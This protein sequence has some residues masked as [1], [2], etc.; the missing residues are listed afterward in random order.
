MNQDSQLETPKAAPVSD[1]VPLLAKISYSVGGINDLYG[2]W[3]YNTLAMAVFNIHL[4][5]PPEK[6]GLALMITR[7]LDGF[8]DPV[9]GTLSDNTRTRFGRRRPFILIGSILSGLALPVMF[10]A[11]P[12][13]THAQLFLFMVVSGLLYAPL[14]SCFNMPYQSLGAEMTPDYHER[15]SLMSWRAMIQKLAG[16]GLNYALVVATLPFF[17]D[18]SGKPDMLKG[19]QFA[20]AVAGVL[21][22]VCGVVNFAFVKERYYEA[23]RKQPKVP[24]LEA[25]RG[26]VRNRPYVILLGVALLF[27]GPT[28]LVA[29]L[30]FYTIVYHVYTGD[31][32]QSADLYFWAGA[33][34]NIFG[35]FLGVPLTAVIS[36]RLGK[37]RTMKWLLFTGAL[38][39]LLS[40]WMFSPALPWGSVICYG[41]QGMTATGVWVILPSMV[42]DTV[43]YDELHTST[44][45]EG[46]Y[47]SYASWTV[48][49]GLSGSMYVSGLILAW[50]GFDSTL[51]GNQTPSA[52]FSIRLAFAVIPGVGLLIGWL[53]LFL[54]PLSSE[55][56]SEMRAAL[57]RRRGAV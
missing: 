23:A 37:E 27:S 14:I 4:G 15:T 24:F 38:S 39:Y 9:F 2:H 28:A 54:Y 1:K 18:A 10:M 8:V 22:I 46:I 11:S 47:S 56:V 12:S 32:T 19:A 7:L 48:K 26:M 52:V 21:M 30:A 57:E 49:L 45:R 6:V 51:G 31:V 50:S 33:A 25:I 5:L 43:D 20:C 36:R 40:W 35:S 3:L 13:W 44:R 42:A 17:N 53:L 34:Y 41:L 55:K 29:Q 16:V